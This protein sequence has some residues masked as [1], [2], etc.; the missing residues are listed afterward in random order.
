ME[1]LPAE[2]SNLGDFSGIRYVCGYCG[3]TVAPAH[4]WAGGY[5]NGALYNVL[6]CTDCNRPSMVIRR[7]RTIETTPAPKMGKGVA[8]LADDVSALYEE[9]RSCTSAGAYTA[10]VLICR[11]LLMHIAVEKGAAAGGRFVD[12]VDYLATNNYIPPDGRDWV[13]YIRTKSNEANHEIVVMSQ[14][15]A[16]DLVTFTEMLLRLV[17]EFKLRLPNLAKASEP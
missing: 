4:G 17:Y 8:G 1:W 11:K 2:W 10:A 15:D 3:A 9:A 14:R 13:D 5:K 12:Y 16:E 7:G 6:V